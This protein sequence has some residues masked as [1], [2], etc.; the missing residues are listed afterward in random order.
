MSARDAAGAEA[1]EARLSHPA[2]EVLQQLRQWGACFVADLTQLTGRL[3]VEVE[4][5]LWELVAAG[6]VTADGFDNLRS[7]IDPK[8][9][10]GQP[11]FARKKFRAAGMNGLGRWTLL[12]RPFPSQDSQLSTRESQVYASSAAGPL[13]HRFSG[14]PGSRKRAGSVERLAADLPKAGG[15]GRDSRRPF[16]CGLHRRAVRL[17]ASGRCDAGYPSGSRPRRSGQNIGRGPTEP[18]GNHPPR[19]PHPPA[20]CHLHRVSR[21]SAAR[22][23]GKRVGKKGRRGKGK[24][25]KR[26]GS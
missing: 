20:S 9:R 6:L 13:G 16:R 17:A 12:R 7:L 15:A 1:A 4:E 10:R 5:G 2:R 22:G 11:R 26:H 18:R 24:E 23:G 8:R 25:G 3:R 14:S 19:H 21:R